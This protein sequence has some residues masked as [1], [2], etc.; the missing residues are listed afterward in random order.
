MGS[1][2]TV[3]EVER[4]VRRNEKTWL[5]PLSPLWTVQVWPPRVTVPWELPSGPTGPY[6]LTQSMIS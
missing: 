4:E 3:P 5:E 6:W 1:M 2:S